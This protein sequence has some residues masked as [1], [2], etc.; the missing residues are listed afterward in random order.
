MRGMHVVQAGPAMMDGPGNM[1]RDQQQGGCAGERCALEQGDQRRAQGDQHG[2]PD[3][4]EQHERIVFGEQGR[5]GEHPREDEPACAAPLERMQQAPHESGDKGQQGSIGVVFETAV[6]SEMGD[7]RGEYRG[8]QHL[9]PTE[10]TFHRQGQQSQ[11]D[12][13][14]DLVEQVIG[15]VADRKQPEPGCR[16]PAEQRGMFVGAP[17]PLHAPG[18]VFHHVGAI[19][20]M[21]GQRENPPP[22]EAKDQD[23]Q[24]GTAW[25]G[26]IGTIFQG[27]GAR[28]SRVIGKSGRS[29]RIPDYD[30]LTASLSNR[31]SNSAPPNA[32]LPAVTTAPCLR[33][34]S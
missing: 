20:I 30:W 9:F 18:I 15:V 17:L 13:Q 28:R 16:D 12:R 22:G 10:D 14:I 27:R 6:G 23:V 25:G 24:Q 19:Q 33:A 26:E 1:R 34:T 31:S 3:G 8:N 4:R 29:I 5:G 7:Q 11:R 32:L 21:A 2:Q